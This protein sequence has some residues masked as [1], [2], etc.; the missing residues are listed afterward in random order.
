[1]H[2]L[3]LSCLRDSNVDVRHK[4]SKILATA[5]SSPVLSNDNCLV[6]SP[7]IPPPPLPV[8]CTTPTKA[9]SAVDGNFGATGGAGVH[10]E[11]GLN[12]YYCD[13]PIND[14]V[15]PVDYEEYIV[16][17]SARILTHLRPILL[18]PSDDILVEKYEPPVRT[19]ESA[20]APEFNNVQTSE[21]PYIQS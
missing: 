20:S 7:D 8:S 15:D 16:S 13:T 2:Q 4:L 19:L 12:N 9:G 5:S 17:N 14:L 10:D 6:A 1:M 3:R 11:S 21:D 18:F